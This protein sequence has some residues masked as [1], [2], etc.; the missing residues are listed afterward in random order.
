MSK[1]AL[2]FALVV[3]VLGL[4]LMLLYVRRFEQ[5]ASGGERVQLLV[6]IKPI[7]RGAVVTDD[8]RVEVRP[9]ST[10]TLTADHRVLD[11]AS[12]ARFLATIQRALEH[13]GVML[14]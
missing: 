12:A 5:Q 13:P 14:E 2:L 3:A 10:L 1:R 6:A 7:E 11:G 4:V 8:D 9:V